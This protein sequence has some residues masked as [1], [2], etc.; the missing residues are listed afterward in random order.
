MVPGGFFPELSVPAALAV[1]LLGGLLALDDTALGQTWFS[2]PLVAGILT[3]FVCGDPGVGLMVAL[4]LQLV[5]A[6]DLPVGQTFVGDQTSAVIATVAAAVWR[7][8]ATVAG[9]AGGLSLELL[10]WML[11][12][13]AVLSVAGSPLIQLERRAHGLWMQEGHL[14]LRDGSLTRIERLHRRCLQATFVRGAVVT[15][16]FLL[17]VLKL[18]LPLFAALP[19]RLHES[20]GLL[21]FLLPA[22]GVGKM[23]ERYGISASWRWVVPGLVVAYA[24]TGYLL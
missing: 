15:L 7:P 5:L 1:G 12:G 3:G 4:P 19:E 11:L 2:L 10:G 24:V 17:V 20:L 9:V 8:A 13:A 23:I 22:L 6:G 18:W 14:T 21:P 16:L